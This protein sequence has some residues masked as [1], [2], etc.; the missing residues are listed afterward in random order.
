MLIEISQRPKRK[1]FSILRLACVVCST[2]E[3]RKCCEV[4]ETTFHTSS[5]NYMSTCHC[6][7]TIWVEAEII[8]ISLCSQEF[9]SNKTVNSFFSFFHLLLQTN[10]FTQNIQIHTLSNRSLSTCH[11]A[12]I[13]VTSSFII[14]YRVYWLFKKAFQKM[15]LMVIDMNESS[16]VQL[17]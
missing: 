12:R 17:Y 2:R 16:T 1:R 6:A 11:R 15:M 13:L 9:K 10:T 14:A 3:K 5:R 7:R 8:L 4:N